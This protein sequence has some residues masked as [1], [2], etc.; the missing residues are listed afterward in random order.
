MYSVVSSYNNGDSNCRSF[1]EVVVM[2]MELLG[3]VIETV[4][5]KDGIILCYKNYNDAKSVFDKFQEKI[6][7]MR[8]RLKLI[9]SPEEEYGCKVI[10][11]FINR[12]ENTYHLPVQDRIN[13]DRRTEVDLMNSIDIGNCKVI[14]TGDVQFRDI[15]FKNAPEAI[16]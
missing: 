1:M 14:Y 8:T 15:S 5:V 11:E 7:P 12:V 2:V 4:E 10:V 9:V 16:E 6:S 13:R 3:F